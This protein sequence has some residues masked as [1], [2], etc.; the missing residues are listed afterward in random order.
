MKIMK[1]MLGAF[2]RAS[3][4]KSR[5]RAGPTP[6]NIS[7]NSEPEILKNL[8]NQRIFIGFQAMIEKNL[9]PL[10]RAPDKAPDKAKDPGQSSGQSPPDKALD[11]GFQGSF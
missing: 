9:P 5:T 4:N 2:L 8:G 6:T 3:V 1:M 11:K 10:G 7:K